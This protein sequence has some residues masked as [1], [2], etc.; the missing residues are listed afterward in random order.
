MVNRYLRYGHNSRPWL[1]SI[2]YMRVSFDAMQPIQKASMMERRIAM[3][4]HLIKTLESRT[5]RST[6]PKGEI[7]GLIKT[8]EEYFSVLN[9]SDKQRIETKS[10]DAVTS[11][12][13]DTHLSEHDIM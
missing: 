2:A 6:L 10:L 8:A 9:E 13:M 3:R 11:N 1:E 5:K 12:V 4:A 7:A